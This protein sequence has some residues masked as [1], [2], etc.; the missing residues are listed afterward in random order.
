MKKLKEEYIEFSFD[1]QYD[2]RKMLE[3]ER[4][5]MKLLR[6]TFDFYP[7]LGGLGVHTT[8]LSKR[9]SKYLSLQL[10]LTLK[11]SR[12]SP[13]YERLT[14]N[15]YII[16][17]PF[18][19][20]LPNTLRYL[21]ASIT[22]FFHLMIKYRWFK[23]QIIHAHYGLSIFEMIIASIYGYLRKIPV[24]WM[25]HGTVE[26][27][28]RVLG[29]LE[30]LLC[31]MAKYKFLRVDRI[32]VLDDGTNGPIK[33]RRL[34]NNAIDITTV[35]HAIDTDYFRPG[36]DSYGDNKLRLFD[37]FVVISTSRLDLHKNVE[38]TI[39]GFARF[40]NK[41]NINDSVLLIIG[42]GPMKRILQRLASR[43]GVSD[44]VYF[45]GHMGLDKLRKYLSM[46][47]VFIQTSL[48][49]NMTRTV[50]EAM[51]MAKPVIVFDSG[52]IDR[53][54]KKGIDGIIVEP[55]NVE[56]LADALY[57]LYKNSTL[58][59]QLGRNACQKILKERSWQFRIDIELNIYKSLLGR[60]FYGRSYGTCMRD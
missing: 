3:K 19:S 1:A 50:Q 36:C 38:Y 6:I 43:L 20:K 18:P 39:A 45:M 54:I 30:S 32:L 55:R 23:P 11:H 17:I 51:A 2:D 14:R 27:W 53:L 47:Q 24:I 37:K 41:Y 60:K 31:L 13:Y 4:I 34:I 26:K 33:F 9:M 46:S 29:Y 52:G 40:L 10:V 42:D 21:I 35:Y 48:I 5:I 16:R 25:F 12:S 8:E 56:G 57:L 15:T 49:S 44:K 28:N 7:A 59:K 58:R 22:L